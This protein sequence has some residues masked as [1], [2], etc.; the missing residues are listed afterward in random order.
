MKGDTISIAQARR[1]ALAAHGFGRP[2]PPGI[3]NR[4]HV[5]RVIAQLKVVQIDSV[6]VLARAHEMPLWSRLGAYPRGVL[7]EMVRNGELFE[8][9][10][11]QA[12]YSPV[13]D[14]PLFQ[15]KMNFPRTGHGH[16][17]MLDL[18]QRRPG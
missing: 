8:Y 6:N 18:Q 2:R 12:S 15:W 7:D 4:G 3:A 5:R 10:A 13:A 9:W 11:H 14:W 16:K 17:Y 1:T